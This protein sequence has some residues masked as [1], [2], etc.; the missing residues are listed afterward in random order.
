MYYSERYASFF[1][2][3][4]SREITVMEVKLLFV[5]L[6]AVQPR[7]CHSAWP[8]FLPVTGSCK[9]TADVNHYTFSLQ[10]PLFV[11]FCLQMRKVECKVV[12]VNTMKSYRE[13]R[14]SSKILVVSNNQ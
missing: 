6:V 5:F 4:V 10:L 12:P 13:I 7:Y 2:S 3:S 8:A 11:T 1:F 14:F 9:K